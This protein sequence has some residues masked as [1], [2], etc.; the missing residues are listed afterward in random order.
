MTDEIELLRSMRPPTADPDPAFVANERNAL[1]AVMS[2]ATPRAVDRSPSPS[3]RRRR[4][5]WLLPVAVVASGATAAA[6]WAALRSDPTTTT[7]VSCGTTVIDARA[8]DPVA[9]CAA[10]WLRE[11]GTAAPPLVAYVGTGGGVLVVPEGQDPGKGFTPL[12]RSFRQDTALIE[13]EGELGDVSRGLAAGCLGESEAK[14]LVTGQFQ[15]LG[16]SDWSITVRTVDPGAVVRDPDGRTVEPKPCPSGAAR[17]GDVVVSENKQ[18]ELIPN[19]SSELP[20]GPSTT[21]ARRLTDQLVEGPDARCLPVDQAAELAR[22]EATRLG[23]SE[24]GNGIIFRLVAPTD[25]DVAT[26]ARPTTTVAGTVEVTIRA[27]PR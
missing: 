1:M 7:S 19:L 17:Y 27:V 9:D 5:R 25:A 26:C 15:R 20:P 14:G 11:H 8:G 3:R 12:A 2:D 16:L 13:L 4:Q 6:G 22:Q 23:F 21:L 24:V 18:V 10:L